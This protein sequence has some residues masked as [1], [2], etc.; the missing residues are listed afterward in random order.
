MEC[1]YVEEWL[2][3]ADPCNFWILVYYEFDEEG[4]NPITGAAFE[5]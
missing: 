1:Y 2:A 3:T 4:D 5:K